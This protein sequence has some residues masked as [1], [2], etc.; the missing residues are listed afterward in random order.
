MQNLDTLLAA[1]R[2]AGEHTR[3]RLLTLCARSELSVSELTQILGQ[4]QPRVSRHL[5]LMVEAGLLERFPEGAQVFY[6]L[7]DRASVAPLAK[8]LVSLLDEKDAV[9]GRD[10][11]RLDQV[12]DARALEAQSYFQKVAENWSDLRKLHVPQEQIEAELR[13]LVGEGKVNRLLDI[14]TGTG[15]VLELLADRTESGV[16][17]D[18]TSGMLAVARNNL[19]QAGLTHMQVR[20]GDMTALPL[21]SRS[22]DLV[23]MNLVLHFTDDP[24]MAIQEAARVLA[25]KGRLFVVDFATH[26]EEYM[27]KEFQHRRLGFT[28]DEVRRFMQ[29]AGLEMVNLKQFVGEPLTVKIWEVVSA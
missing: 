12:K 29:A 23:T 15:R 3:L 26:L 25:P 27:R 28:D 5:K 18:F 11:S 4:S 1:L 22:F 8:V 9:L 2:A 21:A 7:S 24:A 14:G 10:L 13:A 6:R 16:G 19:E 17:V 20:K